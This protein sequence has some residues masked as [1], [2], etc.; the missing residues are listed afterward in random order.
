LWE[1]RN[2]LSLLSAIEA[3]YFILFTL[4]I[5]FKVKLKNIIKTFLKEPVVPAALAFAITFSFAVGINAGNFGTLVRYKIPMMP[6]YV[7]ALMIILDANRKKTVAEQ[8][9]ALPEMYQITD[10]DKEEEEEDNN[11]LPSVR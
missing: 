6:F 2:P 11:D 7:A 1:A 9:L 8:S 3:T 10:E 4:Y 5:L